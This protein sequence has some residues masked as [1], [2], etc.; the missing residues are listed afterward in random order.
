MSILGLLC[1]VARKQLDKNVIYTTV[2][3][4]CIF[5]SRLENNDFETGEHVGTHIDAPCH[6][7]ETGW[8]LDKIP[9]DRFIAPAV[10]VDIRSKA[11]DNP[12]VNL[13]LGDLQGWEAGHG[14]IP[15]GAVVFQCSGWSEKYGV[16]DVGYWGNNQKDMSNF[17]YPAFAA[18]AVEWLASER[19]VVGIGV[20][21]PSVDYGASTTYPTHE[22]MAK[23][24]L[25]GLEHVKDTC[26]LPAS[27]ATV[28]VFPILIEGG[29]GGPTRVIA[30]WG[31]EY[32]DVG[33]TASYS[34]AGLSSLVTA[35]AVSLTLAASWTERR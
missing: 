31:R 22:T 10:M 15:R 2:K 4:F 19:H 33:A 3:S 6:F 24:N 34:S 14:E 5:P 16:D 11:S 18:D 28:Y 20:D 26:S 9:I 32:P 30:M 7:W 25:Y 23:H 1:I 35:I 13:T 29:S 12:D 8:T 27:G 21:V 17:H